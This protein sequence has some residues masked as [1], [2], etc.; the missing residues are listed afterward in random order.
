MSVRVEKVAAQLRDEISG[1]LA[2]RVSDPRVGLVSVIE[3][4][5]SPDLG[6]AKVHVSAIGDEDERKASMLALEHARG[7]VRRELAAHMRNLRRIPEIRFVDDRNLEYAIHISEVI[8]QL[9]DKE[10]P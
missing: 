6:T 9:H 8:E 5:L 7:F 2:R 4:D 1:I 10:A 3:V